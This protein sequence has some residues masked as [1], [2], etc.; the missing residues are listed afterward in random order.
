MSS[1]QILNT[2]RDHLAEKL[3]DRYGLEQEEAR[4]KAHLWLHSIEPQ[5]I[6]TAQ[7]DHGWTPD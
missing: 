3:Q 5:P 1:E 2:W 4:T 7:G 6:P